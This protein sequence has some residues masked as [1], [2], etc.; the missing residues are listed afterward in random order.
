MRSCILRNLWDDQFIKGQRFETRATLWCIVTHLWAG[1]HWEIGPYPSA[2]V[3]KWYALVRVHIIFPASVVTHPLFPQLCNLTLWGWLCQ[4]QDL[5]DELSLYLEIQRRSHHL[6]IF[7]LL[8]DGG[9]GQAET[10]L[11]L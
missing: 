11:A 6:A 8:L 9:L 7:C 2:V 3:I 4:E 1:L 10:L 5:G